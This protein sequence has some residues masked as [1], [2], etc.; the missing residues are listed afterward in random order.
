MNKLP[1][2]LLF[3][4]S[5]LLACR[6]PEGFVFEEY[7]P[8]KKSARQVYYVSHIKEGD[9]VQDVNDTSVCRSVNVSGKEVFFF[10]E[11]KDGDS[12]GCVL[13]NS[14]AQGAVYYE[15]GSLMYSPIFHVQD[16]KIANLY[17]FEA[18]FPEEV[19]IDSAYRYK[20]G[21]KKLIF[22]F[23]GTESLNIRGREFK[24]CLKLEVTEDWP[25]AHYVSTVWFHKGLGV[26]KWHRSTGR[27]EEIKL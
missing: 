18:L 26:V 25:T 24:D 3:F 21:N 5:S 6:G 17:Y 20:D 14:F 16:L 7:Y 4:I 13:C 8:L 23:M 22:R 15:N 12:T 27:L 2:I 19:Q 10:N 11:L 1:V 9:T